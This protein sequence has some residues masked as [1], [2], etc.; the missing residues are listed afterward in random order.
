MKSKISVYG[1]GNYDRALFR[2]EDIIPE[3]R[4][5]HNE[6]SFCNNELYSNLT[7]SDIPQ[8]KGKR[9]DCEDQS[10]TISVNVL[11]LRLRRF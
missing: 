1:H 10:K 9:I 5:L 11:K 8:P 6:F 3:F 7:S 4:K 2:Q